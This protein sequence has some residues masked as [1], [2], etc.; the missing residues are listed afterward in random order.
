M[1][2]IAEWPRCSSPTRGLNWSPAFEKRSAPRLEGSSRPGRPLVTISSSPSRVPRL[3]RSAHRQL[4]PCRATANVSKSPASACGDSKAPHGGHL[5]V[6][7]QARA[8]FIAQVQSGRYD[9]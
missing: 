9:Q 6:T 5:T 1:P 7:P 2:K 3:R 4:G 8:T